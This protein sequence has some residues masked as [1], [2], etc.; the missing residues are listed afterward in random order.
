MC[1][2][3]A[4]LS[5]KACTNHAP[6]HKVY[7]ILAVP[8]KEQSVLLKCGCTE[9]AVK[10][11]L[12]KQ[13]NASAIARRIKRQSWSILDTL[14]KARLFKV[15]FQMCSLS[16]NMHLEHTQGMAY[17]DH[18]MTKALHV[19]LILQKHRFAKVLN[20]EP[21]QFQ[22]GQFACKCAFL[23]QFLHH[24]LPS[25]LFF[26]LRWCVCQVVSDKAYVRAEPSMQSVSSFAQVSKLWCCKHQKATLRRMSCVLSQEASLEERPFCWGIFVAS[27]LACL[28]KEMRVFDEQAVARGRSERLSGWKLVEVG[29]NSATFALWFRTFPNVHNGPGLME[30]MLDQARAIPRCDLPGSM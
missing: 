10:S 25:L 20:K 18:N 24:R 11:N 7:I 14:H 6:R 29:T 2:C 22:V 9:Q 26:V 27:A 17:Y 8:G 16:I 5:Q 3:V 23:H 15:C 13:R 28:R 4:T 21:L 19:S 30:T 12:K 1:H